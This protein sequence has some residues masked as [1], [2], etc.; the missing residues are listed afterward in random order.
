MQIPEVFLQLSPRQQ[1]L[2]AESALLLRKTG[3]SMYA[4]CHVYKVKEVGSKD[5]WHGVGMNSRRAPSSITGVSLLPS[6]HEYACVFGD[7]KD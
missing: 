2:A 1:E 6:L 3:E 4:H 7:R 5:Q